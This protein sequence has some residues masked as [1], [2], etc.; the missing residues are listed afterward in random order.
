MSSGSG[1]G[2]GEE[3]WSNEA[4]PRGS[5]GG[6]EAFLLVEL[7]G[8]EPLAALDGDEKRIPLPFPQKREESRELGSPRRVARIFWGGIAEVPVFTM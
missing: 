6:A 7:A 8:S 2:R 5:R 1:Q 4:G 3:A